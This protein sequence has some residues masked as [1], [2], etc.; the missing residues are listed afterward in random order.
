V[1]QFKKNNV[2][3]PISS[4]RAPQINVKLPTSPSAILDFK[5]W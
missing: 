2:K 1:T 4:V 3:S 5:I